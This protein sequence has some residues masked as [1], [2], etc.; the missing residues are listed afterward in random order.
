[1]LYPHGSHTCVLW[2]ILI[3]ASGTYYVFTVY[4][5]L[6]KYYD[7]PAATLTSRVYRQ[8]MTFPAVSICSNNLFSRAKIMMQDEHPYFAALGLN[9]SA[10]VATKDLRQTEMNYLP[11][12]L[13]MLCCCTYF[14]YPYGV[15]LVDNCTEQKRSSLRSA[16]QKSASIFN[17]EDFYRYYSQDIDVMLVRC[18]FGWE[19]SGVCNS[20]DFVPRITEG[21]L[22]YTY[23]SGQNNQTP[24][25]ITMSGAN[26]GITVLLN[27]DYTDHSIGKFSQGFS[28]SIHTPGE[29]FSSWDAFLVSPGTHAAIALSEQRVRCPSFFFSFFF[30][31]MQCFLS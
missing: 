29:F 22:C 28:I 6:G 30:L 27:I 21:G 7:Y 5:A 1:M 2:S 10:C 4:R 23:N 13:A 24:K 9:L 12:G 8:N 20:S 19:D 15:T 31:F 3:L 18:N 25:I 17:M 14:G 16:I 11:C 26:S